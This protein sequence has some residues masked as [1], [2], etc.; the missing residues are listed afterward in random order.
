MRDLPKVTLLVRGHVE[1]EASF[2][3]DLDSQ[4]LLFQAA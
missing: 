4:S 3:G 2:S 1:T